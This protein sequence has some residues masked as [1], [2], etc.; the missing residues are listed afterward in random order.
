VEKI[1]IAGQLP[2]VAP[3]GHIVVQALGGAFCTETT[4]YVLRP[5]AVT[6]VVDYGSPERY[7]RT[8]VAVSDIVAEVE[9]P[10]SYTSAGVM[11]R[12]SKMTAS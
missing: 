7:A 9:G 2:R 6:T 8:E 5:N 10:S 11:A 1:T 12:L 3:C 4:H